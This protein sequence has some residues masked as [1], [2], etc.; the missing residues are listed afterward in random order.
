[1]ERRILSTDDTDGARMRIGLERRGEMA[2][3]G[4]KQASAED[5]TGAI[6]VRLIILLIQNIGL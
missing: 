4:Y 6:H 3:M 2:G 1:M 5:I